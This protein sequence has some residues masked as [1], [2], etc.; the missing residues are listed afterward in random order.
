[1]PVMMRLLLQELKD[2]EFGGQY[3]KPKVYCKTFEDNTGALALAMV[4]NSIIT[5]GRRL[6]MEALKWS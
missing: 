4:P 3:T 5:L 1:M 2:R 6:E